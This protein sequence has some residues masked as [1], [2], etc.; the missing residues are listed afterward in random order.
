MDSDEICNC[1]NL[2]TKFT[3]IALSSTTGA[4]VVV[5]G[6]VVARE[7]EDEAGEEGAATV[8]C[9]PFHVCS[10]ILCCRKR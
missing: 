3:I 8:V 5:V 4:V 1:F 10:K 9:N 6:V 7:D 2:L